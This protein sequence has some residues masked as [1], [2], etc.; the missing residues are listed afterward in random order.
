M[1]T[2]FLV[3]VTLLAVAGCSRQ[4]NQVS[5]P[6]PTAS[7]SRQNEAFARQKAEAAAALAHEE[8]KKRCPEYPDF[9]EGTET[10]AVYSNREVFMRFPKKCAACHSAGS[11]YLPAHRAKS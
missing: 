7:E 6:V 8:A 10:V 4:Q 5:I 11:Q 3:A 9:D 2:A 1:K